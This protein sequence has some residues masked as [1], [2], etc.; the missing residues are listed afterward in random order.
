M[1]F[2]LLFWGSGYLSTNIPSLIYYILLREDCVSDLRS[3]ITRFQLERFP[4]IGKRSNRKGIK[5]HS[6]IDYRCEILITR[7]ILTFLASLSNYELLRA[8]RSS[9]DYCT[10]CSIFIYSRLEQTAI[11]CDLSE[12]DS[13]NLLTRVEKCLYP[14]LPRTSIMH[15]T[16]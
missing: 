12:L 5:R 1:F 6:S 15:P 13:I 14:I 9:S 4:K 8:L 11:D 10:D 16:C 7:W 3:C 2:S